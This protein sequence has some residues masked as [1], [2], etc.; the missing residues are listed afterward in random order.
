MGRPG[1]SLSHQPAPAAGERPPRCWRKQPGQGVPSPGPLA[2][3]PDLLPEGRGREAGLHCGPGRTRRDNR[4]SGHSF[5]VFSDCFGS[6]VRLWRPW[7]SPGFLRRRPPQHGFCW[8]T[9]QERGGTLPPHLPK[10]LAPTA[11]AAAH[12]GG[13]TQPHAAE[14]SARAAGRLLRKE[15][16]LTPVFQHLPQVSWGHTLP[17]GHR[18]WT[19][20]PRSRVG[21]SHKACTG[22]PAPISCLATRS[23]GPEGHAFSSARCPRSGRTLPSTVTDPFRMPRRYLETWTQTDGHEGLFP[24]WRGRTQCV[25]LRSCLANKHTNKAGSRNSETPQ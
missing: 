2:S 6:P 4:S 10:T 12:C 24:R 16:R 15:A 21:S 17:S 19:A 25:N 3:S 23:H 1:L 9:L 7:K 20:P 13:G 5:Q 18:S 8:R 14:H 11:A 22:V